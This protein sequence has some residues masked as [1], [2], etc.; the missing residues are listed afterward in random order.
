MK[1]K[2]YHLNHVQRSRYRAYFGA[3][4]FSLC[5]ILSEAGFHTEPV[6]Q[7]G[8][9]G[10]FGP[11]A[12]S[13]R[14]ESRTSGKRIQFAYENEDLVNIVNQIAQEKELNVI[15]PQ[16]TNA[17]VSKVTFSLSEKISVDQAW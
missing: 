6:S 4:L 7:W 12:E 10:I 2:L 3:I 15:F 5:S 16:G 9:F 1:E 13:E 8:P 17:I 14:T 11:T